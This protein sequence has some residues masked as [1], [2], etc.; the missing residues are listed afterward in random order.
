MKYSAKNKVNLKYSV[1]K[2]YRFRVEEEDFIIDLPFLVPNCQTEY[3]KIIDC[4]LTI[5][6]KYLWDGSSGPTFQTNACK[7]AS[8]VHDAL[9]QLIK[10]GF[11]GT[12]VQPCADKLYYKLCKDGGMSEIRARIRLLGLKIGSKYAVKYSKKPNKVI[13]I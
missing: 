10:L 2:Q 1:V 8:L 3:I 12:T 11:L 4:E 5:K 9:C 7:I 13:T 6:G